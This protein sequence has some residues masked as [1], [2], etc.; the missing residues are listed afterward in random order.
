MGEI[1]TLPA[2]KL[3]RSSEHG[4]GLKLNVQ[5]SLSHSV[6][7]ESRQR[8]IKRIRSIFSLGIA[9][10]FLIRL[11]CNGHPWAYLRRFL[12]CLFPLHPSPFP[13][14]FSSWPN[15]RPV[16]AFAR[17]MHTCWGPSHSWPMEAGG[18]EGAVIL[19]FRFSRSAFHQRRFFVTLRKIWCPFAMFPQFPTYPAL[20]ALAT[21][22]HSLL[23]YG[24]VS[25]FERLT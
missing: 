14:S 23:V 22:Y 3:G 2:N 1:Q 16:P 18:G 19:C 24:S 15:P 21:L 7:W 12:L 11:L 4:C 13:L 25:S 10:S 20:K 17:A 5:T 8:V 9:Q 6:D